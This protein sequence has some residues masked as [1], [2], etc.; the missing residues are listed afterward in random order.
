RRVIVASVL[1]LV[2]TPHGLLVFAAPCPLYL[3]KQTYASLP[4]VRHGPKADICTAPG[5]RLA[6]HRS[7]TAA[8][9]PSRTLSCHRHRYRTCARTLTCHRCQC[10]TPTGRRV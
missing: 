2:I 10:G 7:L 6:A 9:F 1:M 5:L 8:P 4:H 3:R